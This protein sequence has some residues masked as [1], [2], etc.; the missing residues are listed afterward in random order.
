MIASVEAWDGKARH[1]LKIL[2][3]GSTIAMKL[4]KSR[5]L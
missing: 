5:G 1:T 3:G 4:P 2:G